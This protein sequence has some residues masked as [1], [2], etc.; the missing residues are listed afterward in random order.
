MCTVCHFGMRKIYLRVGGIKLLMS[1][2]AYMTTLFAD[3]IVE[4]MSVFKMLKTV[5]SQY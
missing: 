3:A 1:Y 2:C 4:T 5:P